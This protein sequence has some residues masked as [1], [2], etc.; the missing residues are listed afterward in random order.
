MSWKYCVSVCMDGAPSMQ[1]L[2]K[3]FAA[4]VLQQNPAIKVNHCMIHR[5]MLMSKNLPEKL[6]NTMND[7]VKIANFIKSSALR[8]RIFEALCE[9]M[10]SDYKCLLYHTEVR[11]LSKGKV[12]SR[13]IAMK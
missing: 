8:F 3:G 13:F 2:K 12:L 11:W 1:G 10:E 9:S 7:V 4:F 6:R 5:E